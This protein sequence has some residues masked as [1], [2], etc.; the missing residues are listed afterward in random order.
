VGAEDQQ[1][2]GRLNL[3]H[4][5][6]KRDG[7]VSLDRLGLG[8]VDKTALLYLRPRAENAGKR[9][10]TPKA[11]NGWA[12]L[13]ANKFRSPPARQGYALSVIAS[14]EEGE[15]LDENLYHAHVATPDNMDS[16]T[17]ALHL[18]ELFENHGSVRRVTDPPSRQQG[19]LRRT[20]S[21]LTQWLFS[22]GAIA[23]LK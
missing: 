21:R 12:V 7:L 5:E 10:R 9:F 2:L 19:A 8:N 11:F 4:F 14:P 22:A 15:G 17:M 3:R 23:F 13:T 16:Y 6:E 20:L 1:P 18:R